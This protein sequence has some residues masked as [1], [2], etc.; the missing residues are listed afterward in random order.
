MYSKPRGP[1]LFARLGAPGGGGNPPQEF[2]GRE[3]GLGGSTRPSHRYLWANLMR[4]VIGLD[5]LRCA[6]C[7]SQR[8]L[9]SLIAQKEVIVRILTH[10]NLETDPPV[11]P[12]N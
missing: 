6:L 10:L 1:L 5:V 11:L 4:R 7:R 8:R 2:L 3:Q 12:R 9:I